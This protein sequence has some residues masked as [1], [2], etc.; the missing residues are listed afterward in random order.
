MPVTTALH[1]LRKRKDDL[2]LKLLEAASKANSIAADT[3]LKAARAGMTD[4]D[5]LAAALASLQSAD[6]EFVT[7]SLCN[8]RRGSGTWC[9]VGNELA[10][11]DALFFDIG[12]YGPGGYASDMP[13]TGFVGEPPK[14][15]QD[16]YRQLLMAHRAGEE[17]ARPGVLASRA[18]EAVNAELRARSLPITSYSVG[19]GVGLR[20]CELPTIYRT[21]RMARDDVLEEGMVISLEPETGV[22]LDGRLVILKV[23]D[24]YVVEA[25]CLR[26]LTDAHYTEFGLG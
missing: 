20:A 15:V 22:E 13:R 12:S 5:I 26:R 3:A 8:I 1:D 9:A 24:N 25:G 16:V 18:H 7:H 21:D 6:V 2:E 4:H 17:A 10:E 19:H 11:G 23:E 14:I